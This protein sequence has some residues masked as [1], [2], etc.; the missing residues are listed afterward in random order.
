MFLPLKKLLPLAIFLLASFE[1]G[2]GE[3]ILSSPQVT[4]W[5][6]WK[7]W[8]YCPQDSYVVGMQLKTEAYAGVFSDDSAL[9]GIKFYCDV[10]GSQKNEIS[11]ASGTDEWGSF[12][13]EYF[14]EGVSTAFQLR[15]E[16][17]Q[18]FLADDTAANNLRLYC[19]G[20]D[21]DYLEGDGTE[22]GDWTQTQKC[23]TK[24]AICGIQT[25]VE[26]NHGSGEAL[27]SVV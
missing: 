13:R 11:I 23:F 16:K 5:G 14:C 21:A 25:Q 17:S 4:N 2:R 12:G 18:S 1:H 3:M 10:I 19:N 15:S 8:E 22:F 7:E 27:S 26:T 6:E 24:Q 9:N 20:H